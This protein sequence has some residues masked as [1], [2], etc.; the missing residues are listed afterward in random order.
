MGCFDFYT[1]YLERLNG[2][3]YRDAVL[4]IPTI[5]YKLKSF[6]VGSDRERSSRKKSL[7]V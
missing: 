4:D 2:S 7:D 3:T 6:K 5:D 1:T